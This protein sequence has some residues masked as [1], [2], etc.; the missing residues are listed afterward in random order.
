MTNTSTDQ[1]DNNTLDDGLEYNVLYISSNNQQ[2]DNTGIE[3]AIVDGNVE[4]E[5]SPS[6]I[7]K[8]ENEYATV[9]D[10]SNKTGLT[11]NQSNNV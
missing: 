11:E 2:H 8:T 3:Y 6:D 9:L 1:H 5:S 4:S 7:R 10:N